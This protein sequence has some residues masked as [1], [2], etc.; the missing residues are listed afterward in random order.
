MIDLAAWRAAIGRW[1]PLARLL[2]GYLLHL[3][4]NW[5]SDFLER[6]AHFLGLACLLILLVIGGIE[7]NPGPVLRSQA[8]IANNSKGMVKMKACISIMPLFCL[9]IYRQSTNIQT[10]D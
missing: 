5:I 8:A 7:R 10:N 2:K 4:F 9:Y 3:D 6:L 1:Q